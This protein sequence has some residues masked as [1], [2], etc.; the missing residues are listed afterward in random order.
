MHAL[1]ASELLGVWEHGLAQRPIERALTLLATTLPGTPLDDLARLSIGQR[2][3]G[4]LSLREQNFGPQLVCLTKCTNCGERLELSF[5]VSDLRVAP[6]VEAPTELSLRVDDYEVEFRLPDS[7]AL[8]AVAD[9]RDVTTARALLLERCLRRVSKGDEP[10]TARELPQPVIDAV[11]ERM[12]QADPQADVQL[13][14]ACPLC[15]HEWQTAFDIVSFVWTEINVWASRT[16]YDVHTLA[17]A[18][19]WSEREILGLSP[20]R[21]QAYLEM[22]HR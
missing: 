1:S 19:G 17:A 16:L 10:W 4:L 18:Y 8:L 21:R 6:D 5:M 3:A 2:D 20:R 12:A 14:L 9:S 22:I 11:V 7:F 13:A 15:G